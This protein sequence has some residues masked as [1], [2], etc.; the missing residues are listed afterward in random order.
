[1]DILSDLIKSSQSAFGLPSGGTTGQA[2]VK[3]NATNY[4]VQWATV[5]G[6]GGVDNVDGGNASSTYGGSTTI[7]GGGA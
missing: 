1:M 6:G 4:N 2:L 7:D 5:S 3:V